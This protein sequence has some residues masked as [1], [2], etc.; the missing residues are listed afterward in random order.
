MLSWVQTSRNLKFLFGVDFN[1]LNQVLV[2]LEPFE[3]KSLGLRCILLLLVLTEGVE[4]ESMSLCLVHHLLLILQCR[5]NIRAFGIFQTLLV[6]PLDVSNA[7]YG[8]FEVVSSFVKVAILELDISY[9]VVAYALSFNVWCL[10][11]LKHVAGLS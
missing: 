10:L 8:I 6:Q 9:I 2:H 1:D 4:V 7:L 3:F 11:V 5:N